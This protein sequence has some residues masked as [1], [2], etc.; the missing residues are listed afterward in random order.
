[1]THKQAGTD[2]GGAPP[3]HYNDWLELLL[4]IARFY[5]IDGSAERVRGE[6]EWRHTQMKEEALVEMMARHLGLCAIFDRFNE[7]LLDPWRL[8]MIVD[9]GERGLGVI[10]AISADGEV[11]VRFS[12]ETPL[13]TRLTRQQ[14][15]EAAKRVVRVKPEK[16]VPDARVDDYIKP[17]EEN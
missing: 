15:C 6:A 9:F 4:L 1:M 14:V 3:R 13:A 2:A 10:E 12:G 8:P 17:Y 5:R 16:A 7:G 11:E